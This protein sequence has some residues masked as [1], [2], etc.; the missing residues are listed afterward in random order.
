MNR[1]HIHEF[2]DTTN[3]CASCGG[4]FNP[5]GAKHGAPED[6]ERHI[7]DLGNIIA[8]EDGIARIEISDSKVQ[9]LGPHSVVGRAIVVHAGED[10]LGKGGNAE[11][12][13]T[14]NAGGR[15]ACGKLH[16]C[17]TFEPVCNKLLQGLLLCV[18]ICN[19]VFEDGIQNWKTKS[20]YIKQFAQSTWLKAAV[21]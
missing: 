19:L 21:R 5:Q 1:F 13:K 9:L 10:D 12:L 17:T 14:G 8:N 20:N 16:S 4:H 15:F 7:G 11:S 6:A 3:G 18:L 2:G